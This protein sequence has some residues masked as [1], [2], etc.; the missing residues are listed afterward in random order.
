MFIWSITV[1]DEKKKQCIENKSYTEL[2]EEDYLLFKKNL[3]KVFRE[4]SQ[5]LNFSFTNNM[6]LMTCVAKFRAEYIAE[7][8]S[9]LR[10]SKYRIYQLDN[11]FA[12]KLMVGS[13]KIKEVLYNTQSPLIEH[14]SI[15]IYKD[16]QIDKYIAKL[17]SSHNSI[18]FYEEK[19]QTFGCVISNEDL[20]NN[21]ILSFKEALKHSKGSSFHGMTHFMIEI[22]DEWFQNYYFDNITEALPVHDTR[23]L[24]DLS[25]SRHLYKNEDE[26][27]WN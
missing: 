10:N 25:D 21:K 2:E 27:I 13:S 19:D 17:K 18:I 24:V 1:N 4:Y 26:D 23:S 5:I 9:A 20:K 3:P 8:G 16:K 6:N 7:N 15:I 12:D 22:Q 11:E 14:N